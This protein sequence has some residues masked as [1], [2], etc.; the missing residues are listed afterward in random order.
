MTE[1]WCLP[2]EMESYL[3]EFEIALKAATKAG[4]EIM[5]VYEKDFSSKMKEDG[6]PITIADLKSNKI[7]KEILSKTE[8]QILSEEDKDD[9]K[10]LKQNRI[11]IVDPLDGTSDFV[12]RTG[13]FTVM[14]ALVENKKPILG[15]INWPIEK[16][17][18]VAQKNCGSWKFSDNSWEKISVS[19]IS[20]LSK[21]RA[22][23]SRHHISE[24]EKN[25]LNRLQINEFSSIGSSLK[26]GKVSSGSAEI[27]LTTT[28]KMKEWD[29]CASYCIVNE[30]GGR[31][32]DMFGRDISYNNKVLNHQDGILVTNGLVHDKIIKEY[33]KS[34]K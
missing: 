7:I 31:M 6:S 12:N 19:K 32:T 22:V 2:E 27:Y 26:V 23:G 11:W 18:F 29:T 25:L 14:I 30:A 5:K 33:Q 17:L 4:R 21:C 1:P 9:V 16:T 28:N 10:R 34:R 8:Y 20:E 15:I 3:P 24:E 13:E